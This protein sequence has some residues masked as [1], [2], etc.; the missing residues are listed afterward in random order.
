MVRRI[1]RRVPATMLFGLR[2]RNGRGMRCIRR[3]SVVVRFGR[4]AML[5]CCTTRLLL[6]VRWCRVRWRRIAVPCG[7]R[8]LRSTVC[9][10][11]FLCLRG[12]V[13]WSRLLVIP[14]AFSMLRVCTVRISGRV[15]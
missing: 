1:F 14:W 12:W 5:F 11:M 8:W 10:R 13:L 2:L 4:A 7:L 3:S 15:T 9:R 6:R